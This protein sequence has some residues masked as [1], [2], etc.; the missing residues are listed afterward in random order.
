MTQFIVIALLGLISLIGLMVGSL[1]VFALPIV[2]A[3]VFWFLSDVDKTDA[4]F[5]GKG[6][7]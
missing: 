7:R 3:C 1:T 4:T 6:K 2:L 5:N